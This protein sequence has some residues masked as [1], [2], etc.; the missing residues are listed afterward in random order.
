MAKRI[1]TKRRT[2]KTGRVK[3]GYSQ[4]TPSRQRNMA[5]GQVARALSL[6]RHVWH[7]HDLTLTENTT[8]MK[9]C[10]SLMAMLEDWKPL[11]EV[12]DGVTK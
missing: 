7:N 4:V 5:K 3:G 12:G 11:D 8:M 2:T 10:A 9:V 1:G 6:L